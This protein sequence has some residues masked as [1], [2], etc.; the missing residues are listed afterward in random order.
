MFQERWTISDSETSFAHALEEQGFI[1]AKGD[2]R[3]IVAVDHEG[4]TYAITRWVDV[5][6]KQVRSRLGKPDNLPSV[7]KARNKA[8]E[9][10]ATRLKELELEQEQKA[11]LEKETATQELNSRRTTQKQDLLQLQMRQKE[12]ERKAEQQ[13]ASRS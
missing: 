4:E 13:T 7:A 5:K 10:V 9:L 12:R 2:R 1:L 6:T 3:G 11:Q 8:A